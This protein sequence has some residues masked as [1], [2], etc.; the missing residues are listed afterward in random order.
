VPQSQQVPSKQ[1][2]IRGCMPL[3][4]P[5]RLA[6]CAT[7]PLASELQTVILSCYPNLGLVQIVAPRYCISTWTPFGGSRG[8]FCQSSRLRAT[9]NPCSA[10]V[11]FVFNRPR[12]PEASGPSQVTPSTSGSPGRR[13]G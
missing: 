6:T 2:R 8:L 3:N 12:E 5:H 4:E 10:S 7:E 1:G 11:P 9:S 13:N